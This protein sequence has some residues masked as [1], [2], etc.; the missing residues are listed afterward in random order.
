MSIARKGRTNTTVSTTNSI[1]LLLPAI[2]I[3]KCEAAD[4]AILEYDTRK[5][6]LRCTNL[7]LQTLSSF[8]TSA[9]QEPQMSKPCIIARVM[10]RTNTML[11]FYV[12]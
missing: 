12:L 2:V 4:F 7:K 3:K 1:R 8:E 6:L 5:I 10:T 11:F 9:C